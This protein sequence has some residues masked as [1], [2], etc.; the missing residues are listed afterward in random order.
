MR[1]HY[2]CPRD[3]EE[4]ENAATQIVQVLLSSGITYKKASW[5]LERAKTLLEETKPVK[6]GN[7]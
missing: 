2:D 1:L 6:Q 5:A 4:V 7:L 3:D